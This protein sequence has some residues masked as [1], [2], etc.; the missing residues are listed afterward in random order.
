MTSIIGTNIRQKNQRNRIYFELFKRPLNTKQLHLITGIPRE[1]IC[2]RKR[3][4]EDEGLIKVIKKDFCP[5]TGYYVQFLS[6]D[7]MQ[8]AKWEEIWRERSKNKIPF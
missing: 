7:P 4:L 2:R 6:A 3:E 1:D 5:I 8:W